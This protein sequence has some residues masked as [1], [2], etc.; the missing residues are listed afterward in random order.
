MK[1]HLQKANFRDESA[2][3]LLK[4]Y[5]DSKEL[6]NAELG[7]YTVDPGEDAV[8][9]DVALP[10]LQRD[11]GT[12]RTPAPAAPQV[13]TPAQQTPPAP[14]AA[15]TPEVHVGL[16]ERVLQ[17]GILSKTATYRVIVSGHVGVVEIERLVKKL[18]MD[19]EILADPDPEPVPEPAV[20][21]P[22]EPALAAKP[23]FDL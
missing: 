17:S 8:D 10:P 12:P 23:E 1:W 16:N 18:E 2:D 6:L 4:V 22:N 15:D 9:P 13:Q 11:A 14:R 19:K 5:L 21:A 7:N 3:K 20:D